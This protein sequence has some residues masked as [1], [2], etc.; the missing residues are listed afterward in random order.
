MTTH[1]QKHAPDQD[2]KSQ[3]AQYLEQQSEST[4]SAH[5]WMKR[6]DIAWLGI[7]LAAFVVALYGSFAWGSVNPTLI[8]LAWF[9]FAAC[10]SLMAA[11]F[12]LHAIFIRAFP[13]VILPGKGQ[14]FLTGS[15][16][17]WMGAVSIIGGLVLAVVWVLFGYS[18]ATFNLALL[19]PLINVLGVV[20]GIT[21]LVSLVYAFYQKIS[22]AR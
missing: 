16:A 5:K 2:L 9:A 19:V 3:L 4:Q 20:M 14:T 13:P 21:I 12:G 8:P 11:L 22:Q 15:A 18:A 7:V 10:G 17:A 1:I 6:V